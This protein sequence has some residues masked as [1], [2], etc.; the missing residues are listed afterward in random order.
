[1]LRGMP[2]RAYLGWV[3]TLAG[4]GLALALLAA[5]PQPG[6]STAAAAAG[7]DSIGNFLEQCPTNDPAYSQIRNDFEIRREG[8]VVGALTC[9]EPISALPN[10]Q[11]TDELIAVQALRTI[12][13]MDGGRSVPYPWTQG[14]F[15]DWMKSKIG[16][17]DI[18]ANGSYC[19]E[20]YNGRWFVVIKSHNTFEM[21]Q[22]K[23]WRGI[24]Q[25]IALLGHEVRHVNGFPHVGGCPL[26]P[27][28]TYGCD[29]AYDPG[30]L[31]P[32]GIEWWLHSTWLSGE[33]NV[34]FA[35][36][37][38]ATTVATMHLNAA[39]N[40]FGRRFV[41]QPPPVLTMPAQPGGPCT[42]SSP[43]V[44]PAPT[45]IPTPPATATPGATPPGPTAT[46]KPLIQG[47]VDCDGRV[48]GLDAVS[49]L[50]FMLNMPVTQNEPCPN[51]GTTV[52][53]PWGDV[54]CNDRVDSLDGVKLLRHLLFGETVVQIEPCSDLGTQLQ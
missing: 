46:P 27:T 31:S 50:R 48:S 15:Y 21:R 22:Y 37:S 9:T 14:S 26:F 6:G 53:G 23:E 43:T 38:S 40:D 54:D 25:I 10:A 28:A 5:P 13:Y 44:T 36:L 39:N 47:D 30:N 41:T 18:R 35:C 29:P 45:P 7:I 2:R 19:C 33:I 52:S 42:G 1:M 8:V 24:S 34:G 4:A 32:Y 3:V 17:V 16:G 20:S 49:L 12:L 11:Y 51:I